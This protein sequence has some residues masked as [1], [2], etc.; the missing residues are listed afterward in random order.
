VEKGWMRPVWQIK[1]RIAV[2][3]Q[4]IILPVAKMEAE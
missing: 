3:Q 4:M 2:K 1:K